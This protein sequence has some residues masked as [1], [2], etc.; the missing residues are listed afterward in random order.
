MTSMVM[1]EVKKI[2]WTSIDVM[3]TELGITKRE[4]FW[5]FVLALT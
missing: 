5:S 2:S 3:V 4:K 1:L